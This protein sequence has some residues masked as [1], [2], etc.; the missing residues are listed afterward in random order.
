MDGVCAPVLGR[1]ELWPALGGG[2]TVPAAKGNAPASPAS[3]KPKASFL[4]PFL[5]DQ[6]SSS[7]FF[8]STAFKLFDVSIYQRAAIS[9]GNPGASNSSQGDRAAPHQSPMHAPNRSTEDRGATAPEP[10]TMHAPN[11]R[12]NAGALGHQN[13][14]YAPP[15]AHGRGGGG[16]NG[17]GSRR[18]VG[19]ANGRGNGSNV[20]VHVHVNGNG[21]GNGSERGGWHGQEH[22]RGFN[23]QRR[24]RDQ[25]HG[26][27]PWHRPLGPQMG[28]VE[29][30]HPYPLHPS[31]QLLPSPLFMGMVALPMPYYEPYLVPPVGYGPYGYP[32]E[33]GHAYCFLP[34]PEAQFV[35]YPAL[36]T[37]MI[38]PHLDQ[39]AA[40]APYLEH[41]QQA[42]Q[43]PLEEEEQEAPLSLEKKQEICKQIEYYFSV[44]NLIKD[45]HLR[46]HMDEEGWVPLT[47]VASF[48]LIRVKTK[49]MELILDA[50]SASTEV[51]VQNMPD[52]SSTSM[53]YR[54]AR[55]ESAQVGRNTRFPEATANEKFL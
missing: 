42:P 40:V 24:G 23:G 28:Y 18:P 1:A 19:G 22:R 25:H 2:A 26:H 53:F 5:F 30:P 39:E 29:P 38:P 52:I 49:N 46:E 3:P 43:Q 4:F 51:E 27:G 31:P 48:P 45:T 11:H 47:L 17:G 10:T 50:I 54:M 6:T 32:A 9:R 33:F 36:P 35:T 20:N 12:S 44:N 16:Y 8:S 34:P 55:L 7:R 21:Y 37:Y 14:R 13:G 15:H 41:Q